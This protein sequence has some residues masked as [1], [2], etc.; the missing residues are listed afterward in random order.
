MEVLFWI[1]V[2]GFLA[3]YPRQFFHS[4][5]VIAQS[6]GILFLLFV[7]LRINKLV[8]F[9][10]KPFKYSVY[11]R[12]IW[13]IISTKTYG[14]NIGLS[15]ALDSRHIHCKFPHGYSLQFKFTFGA[16]ELDERNWVVD[17]G[18]LKASKSMA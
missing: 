1:F 7:V 17:F 10:A 13:L 12:E 4:I 9:H 3:F 18:G 8:A 14:H 5:Q 16:S 11:R 15:V 2:I 6:P